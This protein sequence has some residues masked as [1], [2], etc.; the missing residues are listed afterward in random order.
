MSDLTLSDEPDEQA[1]A[2]ARAQAGVS[3][4]LLAAMPWLVTLGFLLFWELAVRVLDVAQFILPAPSVIFEAIVKY[5]PAIWSNSLQTLYTTLLGFGLAIVFGLALGLAI[6]WSKA[7]YAG[8]YPLMIG[9]NAITKMGT[10]ATLGM[11]L[12]PII[13]G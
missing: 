8:L 6:G 4:L 11:A 3:P 13:R 7:V 9:F 10:T 5:W 12:N 1:V 2:A